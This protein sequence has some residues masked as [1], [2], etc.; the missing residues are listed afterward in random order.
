MSEHETLQT[1]PEPEPRAEPKPEPE[2]RGPVP[3]KL[4]RSRDDRVV[5]GVAGG[6]G[7]YFGV[8]PVFFRVGFVALA[9]LGGL[10]VFLYPAALL[11]VPSEVSAGEEPPRRSR[12]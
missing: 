9:F 6:L 12:W 5:A 4:L 11:F 1:G 7:K 10:G 3:R 2:D 8:D